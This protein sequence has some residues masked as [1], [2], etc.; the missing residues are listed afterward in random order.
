MAELRFDEQSLLADISATWGEHGAHAEVCR[1]MIAEIGRLRSELEAERAFTNRFA[2]ALLERPFRG[3]RR[4]RM[5][6]SDWVPVHDVLDDWEARQN[7]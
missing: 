6:G 7:R 5:Y 1:W 4:D 2:H 3:D